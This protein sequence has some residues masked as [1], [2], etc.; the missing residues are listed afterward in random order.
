MST[1]PSETADAT[2]ASPI[3]TWGFGGSAISAPL[4]PDLPGKLEYQSVIEQAFRRWA[5]VSGITFQQ[6]TGTER[7][8][9]TIGWSRFDTGTS[10]IVGYTTLPLAASFIQSGAVIS[11]EDPIETSLVHN[12]HGELSYAGTGATLYQIAAHEIGHALGL[13]D[14]SD[15]QSVMYYSLGAANRDLD[16]TD[17]A[18]VQRAYGPPLTK[19]FVSPTDGTTA[20]LVGSD[21][22][23]RAVISVIDLAPAMTQLTVAGEVALP[24]DFASNAS[25]S[26]VSP[27]TS[28]PRLTTD[29]AYTPSFPTLEPRLAMLL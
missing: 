2:W 28:L 14:N 19:S 16:S 7:R 9:I 17:L 26:L 6:V 8:D 5:G 1:L 18:A 24:Q 11:L 3:I 4:Q 29:T 21:R 20:D 15:P 27:F 22:S 25:F 13:S 10:N 23:G 12:S